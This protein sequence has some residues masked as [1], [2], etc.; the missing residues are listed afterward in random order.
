M[1]IPIPDVLIE[2]AASFNQDISEWNTSSVTNL[3]DM[4]ENTPALSNAN[5]GKIHQSF[6]SN[7][8]WPYD[9]SQYA[10][11]P[12]HFVDLN[13]TVNLEM[14]WVEPGTFIMGSP[15]TEIGRGINETEHNVTLTKGFYLGK[16][17]VTQK[18]YEAVMKVAP[19]NSTLAPDQLSNLELWLD[20]NHSSASSGTWQDMSTKNNDA[21]RTG[22]PSASISTHNGLPVMAYTASG[23]RH[24]FSMI[25]NIR[26]VFWVISQDSSVNGSG[27]RFL[28]SDSTKHPDW[29]NQGN[30]KFWSTNVWTN[31]YIK[32]G[33]TKLNGSR[34]NGTTTNYPNNLSIISVRTTGNVHA[35][36]FGY[37]RDNTGRLWIGYL[38]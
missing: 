12:N 21:V 19:Y 1:C 36:N 11:T 30:G 20:A 31:S 27:Y 26:T 32:E 28:L 8:N 33:V 14:I 13:S 38:G 16:Y 34:I 35:D 5:K 29:H 9:W 4:F 37:D 25:N 15:T 7:S 18:H 3:T 23:Q 17:E 6:S 10:P 22:S 2:G 24:K